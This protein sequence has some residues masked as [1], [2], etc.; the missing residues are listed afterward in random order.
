M[1][2]KGSESHS[3]TTPIDDHHVEVSAPVVV[4]S[5]LRPTSH[6][7]AKSPA[8]FKAPIKTPMDGHHVQVSAI[9]VVPSPSLIPLV[10]RLNLL[11]MLK[12]YC[13][14]NY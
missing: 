1:Q 13:G 6:R 10:R 9:V 4:P 3:V 2:A 12:H 11:E 8:D 7:R 5:P 14:R